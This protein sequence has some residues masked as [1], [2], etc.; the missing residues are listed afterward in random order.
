MNL[1]FI[2]ANIAT[3]YNALDFSLC[4]GNHKAIDIS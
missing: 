4:V 1:H 3:S 2:G